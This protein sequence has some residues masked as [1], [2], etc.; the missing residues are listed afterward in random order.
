MAAVRGSR[1][2]LPGGPEG[3]GIYVLETAG[4]SQGDAWTV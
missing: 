2:A 3:P 4:A 1:K